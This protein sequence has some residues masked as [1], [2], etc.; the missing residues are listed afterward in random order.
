MRIFTILRVA[1]D[2]RSIRC[3]PGPRT[4]AA[5]HIWCARHGAQRL[6]GAIP[7]HVVVTGWLG[8]ESPLSTRQGEGL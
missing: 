2:V 5:F 4:G 6:K 1:G 3:A 8:G 7:V